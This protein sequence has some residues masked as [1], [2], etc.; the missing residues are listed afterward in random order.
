WHIILSTWNSWL[1]GD[2]R[3]FRSSEHKIHSSGDYKNPPPVEEHAALRRYH[4][5]RAGETILIPDECKQVAGE[6]IIEKLTKKKFRVLAVAVSTTHA[7]M[8]VELPTDI[9]KVRAIAG[10]CKTASSHAIRD[11]IPGRV[12]AGGGK[13]IRIDDPEH[14]RNVFY[15]ILNQENAWIWRFNAPP[16]EQ[17]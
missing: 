12:W 1:P 8:L 11:Q 17:N 3:G 16:Q 7:H 10:Q 15:Y 2:V 4:D 9:R 6:A 13:P 14:Q 5:D